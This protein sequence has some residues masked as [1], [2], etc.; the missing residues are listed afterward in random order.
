MNTSSLEILKIKSAGPVGAAGDGRRRP[1]HDS[2]ETLSMFALHLPAGPAR[3][4]RGLTR[5][6][7]PPSRG[8]QINTSRTDGRHHSG[9]PAFYALRGAP[10]AILARACPAVV[11]GC[12][13]KNAVHDMSGTV[14]VRAVR[15][16]SEAGAHQAGPIRP[17]R[18]RVRAPNS[19]ADAVSARGAGQMAA[20]DMQK[21]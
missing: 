8:G 21:D 20:F 12:C 14:P 10:G 19:G 6:H 15:I 3:A 18:P 5:R 2:C 1:C 9:K 16:D 17:S 11:N 7:T 13:R 4:G